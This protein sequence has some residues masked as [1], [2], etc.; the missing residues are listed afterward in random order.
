MY[1][2]WLKKG[3]AQ[4]MWSLFREKSARKKQKLISCTEPGLYELDYETMIS[5]LKLWRMDLFSVA[6]FH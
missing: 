4:N 6:S 2:P 3:T 5:V 1:Y